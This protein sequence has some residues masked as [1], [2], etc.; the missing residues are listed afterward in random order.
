MEGCTGVRS[1]CDRKPL[2][3]G[4][5]EGENRN[6][7]AVRRYLRVYWVRMR[8]DVRGDEFQDRPDRVSVRLKLKLLN[9]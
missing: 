1:I 2:R 6:E 9:L 8:E 3:R 5:C 7:I 4:L